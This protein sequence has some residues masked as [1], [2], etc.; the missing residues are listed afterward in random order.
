MHATL[1][2][3]ISVETKPVHN[4]PTSHTPYKGGTYLSLGARPGL[5]KQ[6][7]AKH[8]KPVIGQLFSIQFLK[9]HIHLL[10]VLFFLGGDKALLYNPGSRPLSAEI[11]NVPQ[12]PVF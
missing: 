7:E 8:N 4:S 11:L 10:R 3:S 2:S 12:H 6:R 9:T 1:Q 5:L